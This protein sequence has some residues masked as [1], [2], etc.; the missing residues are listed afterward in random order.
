MKLEDIQLK[1]QSSQNRVWNNDQNIKIRKFQ[2]V[3]VPV[4]LVSHLSFIDD[5]TDQRVED[6]A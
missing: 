5:F 2:L 1:I 3:T 6:Q 4:K